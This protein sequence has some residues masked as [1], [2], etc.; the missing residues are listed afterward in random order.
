MTLP[1]EIDALRTRVAFARESDVTVFAVRGEDARAT[2]LHLLPSSLTLR[3][4]QAR[5]SLLLD[6]A[7]RPIADVLVCADDEDYLLVVEGLDEPG[8]LAH[9]AAHLPSGLEPSIEPL[10]SSHEVMSLDG[11]WAWELAAEVLGSD[12]MA[13]PYLN[14]FRIDQ[15]FCVRAGKTGEFGYQLVV[16]RDLADGLARSIAEAGR[17]FGLAE[18][19][20]DTL[21]LSRFEA[22]FFDPRSVPEGATP[23]ELQLQWRLDPSREW[24]GKAAVDARRASP[25]R[26]RLTCLLA[27][28]EIAPGDRVHLDDQPIGELVR[29]AFSPVR[30]EW[31]ASAL[32]DLRFA[33]AGIDRYSVRRG[34]AAV[35]VRTMAPPLVDNRSLHVDA[36][37][38]TYRTSDEITFGP[39]TRPW[40]AS[41]R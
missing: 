24:V 15:G 41:P 4:A 12:L 27:E 16:R 37:R 10:S 18:V 36:R 20:A 25:D 33:H 17:D 5:E 32:V 2:L 19:G 7:G 31:I 39:L 34:A 23:V 11:P 26:R 21:S 38:H 28:S 6:E 30:G 40:R 9:V 3:D 22:W 1:P 13:L 29:A 8:V 35:P 14:Y